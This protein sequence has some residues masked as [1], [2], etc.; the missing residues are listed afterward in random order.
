MPALETVQDYITE[1]RRLLQDTVATAYRYPDADLV[2]AL[3]TGLMEARR[4]RADLFLPKFDIPSFAPTDLT[5]PVPMD[6]MYRNALTYYIVGR[7][8]LRDEE[9]TQDSRAASFLGSFTAKLM[10]LTT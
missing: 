7:I 2:D 5:M 8:Q 6:P 9:P 3:N 1:S 10:T 4:L